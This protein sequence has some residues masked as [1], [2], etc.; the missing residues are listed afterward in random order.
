[1]LLPKVLWTTS[2]TFPF[3]TLVSVGKYAGLLKQLQKSR[4]LLGRAEGDS[5]TLRRELGQAKDKIASLKA[6]AER[7][8]RASSSSG[9]SEDAPESNDSS[10]VVSEDDGGDDPDIPF[11]NISGGQAAAAA[12]ATSNWQAAYESV[13]LTHQ[14]METSHTR[15]MFDNV[16]PSGLVFSLSAGLSSGCV[17]RW[18][19]GWWQ[20]GSAW[21]VKCDGRIRHLFASDLLGACVSG[22]VGEWGRI[23]RTAASSRIMCLSCSGSHALMQAAFF[24]PG[25]ALIITVCWEE[26]I[27]LLQQLLVRSNAAL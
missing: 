4:K 6:Q 16:Q 18:A 15:G 2:G 26:A 27:L 14:S 3:V 11:F 25:N 10:S 5:N 12:A 19:V 22:L 21:A 23:G 13:G 8:R 9:S 20:Q 1:M 24:D 7:V 17:G